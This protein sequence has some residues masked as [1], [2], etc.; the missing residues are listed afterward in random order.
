MTLGEPEP[1]S[2]RYQSRGPFPREVRIPT[3]ILRRDLLISHIKSRNQTRILRR[4]LPIS[5]EGSRNPTRILKPRSGLFESRKMNAKSNLPEGRVK[6]NV[7]QAAAIA[8]ICIALAI[9][10]SKSTKS[11]KALRTADA[12]T[13]ARFRARAR[14]QHVSRTQA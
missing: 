13:T 12:H 7:F 9:A 4:D 5:I 3:R 14:F 6:I 10:T 2:P 8:Q 11:Q 1:D